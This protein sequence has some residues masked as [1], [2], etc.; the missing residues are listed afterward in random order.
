MLTETRFEWTYLHLVEHLILSVD[1]GKQIG[2]VAVDV[3]TPWPLAGGNAEDEEE[4][5]L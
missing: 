1:L 2:S 5:E 4:E 3:R